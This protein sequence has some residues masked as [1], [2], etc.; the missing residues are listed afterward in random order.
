MT[1]KVETS[2][3]EVIKLL[4][5]PNSSRNCIDGFYN[6]RLKIKITC[7]PER[8]RANRELLKFISEKTNIP[9]KY[10]RIISGEKSNFKEISLE[11]KTDRSLIELLLDK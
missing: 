5:R 11:K 1:D 7:S 2:F 6:G 4:V 3:T 9:K 8:G 10:F